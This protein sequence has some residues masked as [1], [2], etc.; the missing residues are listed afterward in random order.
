MDEFRLELEPSPR[1]G[2]YRTQK[3]RK[4]SRH[5]FH[6]RHPSQLLQLCETIST[7]DNEED[8]EESD[9]QETTS[10]SAKKLRLPMP[11]L[12]TD[13]SD[14]SVDS[15]SSA[16]S[17]MTS[18]SDSEEDLNDGVGENTV[19]REYCPPSRHYSLVNYVQVSEKCPLESCTCA[20]T[21]ARQTCAHWS[22]EEEWTITKKFISLLLL[23]NTQVVTIRTKKNPSAK[24][25]R[26][27]LYQEWF[28]LL[29]QE[30]YIGP[31]APMEASSS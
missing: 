31:N 15:Y 28:S 3:Q 5:Y 16:S 1:K 26:E 25:P 14:D 19:L 30:S 6:G 27:L 17:E 4:R 29:C 20:P 23:E 18:Y 12:S 13:I 8:E 9:I 11:S 10:V 24:M 7:S 21:L 2:K 22:E